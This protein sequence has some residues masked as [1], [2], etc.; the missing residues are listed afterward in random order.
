V[1]IPSP[2]SDTTIRACPLCSST[3]SDTWPPRGVNF[4]A[5]PSRLTRI[6][7]RRSASPQTTSAWGGVSSDSRTPL[8]A[9]SARIDSRAVTAR[10]VTST[11][12]GS[13]WSR[14]VRLRE[15]SI[16][17]VTSWDWSRALRWITS[18]ACTVRCALSVPPRS[19]EAQPMI[20][21]SGV[22]SSCDTM[23]RNSSLSRLASSAS[24]RAARSTSSILRRSTS[25]SRMVAMLC[26]S[27]RRSRFMRS[28][29][30]TE[31]PTKPAKSVRRTA[32]SH[33]TGSTPSSIGASK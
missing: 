7:R 8:P 3:R 29:T 6:C 24:S 12:D 16:R 17:S 10:P 1:G 19:S 18:S 5:F 28:T 4:N 30:T 31:P 21:L 33:V 11:A 2:V 22:R 20:A 26:S 27:W 32:S 14:P 9:N 23:A 15:T 13:R 25:S